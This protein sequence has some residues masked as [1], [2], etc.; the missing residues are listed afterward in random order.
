MLEGG[1]GEE[2]LV[3]LK[4]FACD[5]AWVGDAERRR[6]DES[7]RLVAHFLAIRTCIVRT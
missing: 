4:I 3:A 7:R 2:D 1:L 6:P 5:T